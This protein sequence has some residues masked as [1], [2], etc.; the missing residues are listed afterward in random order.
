M[1]PQA[2][3]LR[4]ITMAG[5]AALVLSAGLAGA[6]SAHPLG[7]FTINHY[8]G[9]RIGTTA[10]IVDYVLDMAEIPTYQERLRIDGNGD[11]TVDPSETEAERLGACARAAGQL[12]LTVGG[13]PLRLQPVAAGL[14]FPMG[15]SGLQTLRLVCE[16]S[17]PL[18]EPFTQATSVSFRDDTWS[19]RIGWREIVVLG[20]GVSVKAEGLLPTGASDRLA[21]Y[22]PD[23]LAQPLAMYEL[24]VTVSPGGPAAEPFTAPD[25]SALPGVD[26][27]AP[28]AG[29]PPAAAASTGPTVASAA[30]ASPSIAVGVIPGGI[31]DEIS[32]ILE[33]RDLTPLALIGSLLVAAFLGA[34]HAISPGHGKTV[35]AAYLVGSRGSAR[36][37]L[38]LGLTVT[39]SHTLGVMVL[40]LVTLFAS[41]IIPPERLYPV[42]GL[43]S[44]ALVVGIG[45]WLL[46]GRYRIWAH[47]R[48]DARAHAEADRALQAAHAEHHA[49]D[50]AAG[51]S[52][53]HAAPIRGA[54][55]HAAGHSHDHDHENATASVGSRPAPVPGEHSH[56]GVRH[57]HLPPPGTGLTWRSLFTLGLAGGL[58]PSASA[59][60]LLLGSLAANRP[61]YGVILVIAFGAGMAVVLSGVGLLLVYASR[62][63]ERVPRGG[64][65]RR[66]VDVMPVATAVVVIGAGVYLTSQA[67]TQVF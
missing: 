31:T 66:L 51:H 26:G 4:R 42:L 7:N 15:P 34:V 61:A 35:M 39:A 57:T 32:K 64:F 1:R 58:V 8:A 20:D 54:A 63:V 9:L 48:A 49:A 27:A 50:H 52:H 37:A 2:A 40:A 24:S 22:P 55:D 38:A 56:G 3:R 59:L 67:V 16:F 21:A 33:V 45:L 14:S 30:A 25:A 10:I 41:S 28:G 65:G 23:L 11:G 13:T 46:Y 5:M 6:L 62:V 44:G 29:G 60:L 53:D 43:L 17:A 19:Q 18:I 12:R 36:H 47:A